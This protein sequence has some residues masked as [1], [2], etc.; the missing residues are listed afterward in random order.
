MRERFFIAAESTW[1]IDPARPGASKCSSYVTEI[2]QTLFDNPF[3]GLIELGSIGGGALPQEK[4]EQRFQ[5]VEAPRHPLFGCR[6][7]ILGQTDG[8]VLSAHALAPH[9][10]MPERSCDQALRAIMRSS[11][12]SAKATARVQKTAYDKTSAS[13]ISSQGCASEAVKSRS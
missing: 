12:L 2:S 4:G 3:F 10:C 9:F 7:Q 13:R 8:A 5:I 11:G 1:K 6:A